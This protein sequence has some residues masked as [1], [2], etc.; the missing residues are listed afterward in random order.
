MKSVHCEGLAP[1]ELE[2]A[3]AMP[4]AVGLARKTGRLTLTAMLRRA[5]IPYGV[6]ARIIRA[7]LA[8]GMLAPEPG[9]SFGYR[10]TGG[11]S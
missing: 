1:L 10:W 8:A 7:M 2:A 9:P 11:L 6:G 3:G 5:G 4:A